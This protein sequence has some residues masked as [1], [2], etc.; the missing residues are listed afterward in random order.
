MKGL[1]A[2]ADYWK[3]Q[4]EF[5]TRLFDLF[6]EMVADLADRFSDTPV[7]LRPHPA[8]NIE[9]WR[10]MATDRD[11]LHVVK[12]G[13]VVPWMLAAEVMIHN[14]CMTAIECVLL[15]KP[16]LAYRPLTS[17]A[18]DRHL[19]NA[20]SRQCFTL[21]ELFDRVDAIVN[22]GDGPDG[23][24]ALRPILDGYISLDERRLAADLIMDVVQEVQDRPPPPRN[25]TAAG[26]AKAWYAAQRRS[27]RKWIKSHRRDH[28]YATW[29]QK[30][31]F[32]DLG[33]PEIEAKIGALR[34]AL[35]RFQGVT[36]R[37]MIENV[38]LIEGPK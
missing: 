29:H 6:R 31:Q 28:R 34:S 25:G 1:A 22:G 37:R 8:E 11:N 7:V 13:N 27:V 20:V 4:L 10:R 19:P 12:E 26:Y 38:F 32:P 30:H 21:E 23:V 9:T 5:R 2:S 16:A 24:E 14:G 35:G 18:Y 17:D 15:D 3:G 33:V 36:A